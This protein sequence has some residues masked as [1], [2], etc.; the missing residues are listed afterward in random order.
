[1]AGDEASAA[2]Y[3]PGVAVVSLRSVSPQQMRQNLLAVNQAWGI[4]PSVRVY[5]F[6]TDGPGKGILLLKGNGDD[7]KLAGEIVAALD[8]LGVAPPPLALAPIPLESRRASAIKDALLALAREAK[9]PWDESRFVVFPPGGNGELFFRGPEEEAEKVREI[10]ERLDQS[11]HASLSDAAANFLRCFRKDLFSHF[12]TVST[13]FSAA[14]LLLLVHFILVKLPFLGRIYER[15]FTLIW[16]KILDNVRGRDFAYEVI[17]SLIRTAVLSTEQS[18]RRDKACGLAV[19]AAEKKSR[20]LSVSRDLLRFRGFNPDDPQIKR[21]T[22]DLIEAEVEGQR[23]SI[24][25]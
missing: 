9:L 8:D 21:L 10:A 7:V 18:A 24:V 23:K 5:V 19:S 11:E 12:L 15:W 4:C 22:D 17:K 13:Y 20:A 2:G 16:T 1:V 14:L 3:E 25:P 6:G